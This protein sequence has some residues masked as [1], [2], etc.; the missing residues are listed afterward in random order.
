[1]R[2]A[3]VFAM[4]L[5]ASSA[6][7]ALLVTAA[8]GCTINSETATDGGATGTDAGDAAAGD[9]SGDGGGGGDASGNGG[10]DA[11]GDGSAVGDGGGVIDGAVGD[12]G[13]G[14][15]GA[16]MPQVVQVNAGAVLANPKVMPITYDDDANR[17]DIEKFFP[18]YAE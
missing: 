1:M 11:S 12:A 5:L 7:V 13:A 8:A 16:L 6:S 2:C 10:G 3:E 4:R 18:N 14:A 15:L 9:D 17:V